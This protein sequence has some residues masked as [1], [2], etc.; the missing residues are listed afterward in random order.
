[1]QAVAT[2]T[3]AD[4]QTK[5]IMWDSDR[6]T[7]DGYEVQLA[8]VLAW[9]AAGLLAWVSPETQAWARSLASWKSGTTGDP[10]AA[11]AAEAAQPTPTGTAEPA[12]TPS[13]SGRDALLADIRAALA[14]RTGYEVLS[15]QKSDLE[16]RSAVAAANWGTGKKKV[17]FEAVL[18][19]SDADRTVY[20]WEI[21]KER[22]SG[23]SF[24]AVETESYTI[25]GW[26]RSGTKSETVA[27][28]GG[29]ALDYAWDYGQT[30]DLIEQA[31]A[32]HGYALKVVLRKSKAER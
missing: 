10:A 17:D 19:V 18:T 14:E 25:S 13:A 29:V 4:G 26:K 7:V 21:L 20:Y 22:G 11:A 8:D 15:G 24:G 23:L 28:P 3:T 12:A 31:C 16:I 9:D 5:Q 27:G 32:R 6:F 2:Y 1:M 30:R